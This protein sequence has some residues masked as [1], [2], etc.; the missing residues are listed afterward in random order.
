MPDDI[1]F[2][3]MTQAS[4]QSRSI[5]D[6]RFTFAECSNRYSGRVVERCH[7]SSFARHGLCLL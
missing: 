5:A 7:G 2:S 4:E 1:G 3:Q 6:R